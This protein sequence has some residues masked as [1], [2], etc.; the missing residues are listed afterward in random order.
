MLGGGHVLHALPGDW[1]PPQQKT[2]HRE[3]SALASSSSL[4]CPASESLP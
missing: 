4:L 2:A 1:L 3:G